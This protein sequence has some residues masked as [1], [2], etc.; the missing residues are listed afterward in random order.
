MSLSV[1][2]AMT[3]AGVIGKD[4]S[5]P[6]RL[7]E[8]LRRF[9]ALTMGHPVVMGRKTWDSLPRRP[10]PGRRNLVLSRQSDLALEGAERFGDL[11]A[12]LAALPGEESFVIGGRGLFEA[13]LP[14]AARLYLTLIHYPFEGDVHFPPFKASDYATRRKEVFRAAEGWDYEFLDL[15]RIA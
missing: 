3:D 4:G 11:E 14:K 9:K 8:D 7:S 2:A 10:L 15:E 1:I 6:W 13:A 12:A 5:L